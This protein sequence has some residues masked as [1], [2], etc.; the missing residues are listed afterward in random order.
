MT[1]AQLMDALARYYPDSLA[2]KDAI[3]AA[4]APGLRRIEVI[5]RLF[6]EKQGEAKR[7]LRDR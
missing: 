7:D 1:P 2:M 6:R 5:E 4:T 3:N